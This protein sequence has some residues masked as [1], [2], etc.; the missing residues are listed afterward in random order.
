VP[1]GRALDVV[2][3]PKSFLSSLDVSA[4]GRQGLILTVTEPRIAASAMRQQF[5]SFVSAKAY[6][7]VEGWLATHIDSDLADASGLC[8][9]TLARRSG[10]LSG[11]EEA[12]MSR[13]A[14]ALPGIK[15]SERAYNAYLDVLRQ[16][17]F[18]K[19]A[20]ELRRA[21][22]TFETNPDEFKAMAR[23]VNA[24]TGRGEL[25]AALEKAAPVLNAFIFSPRNI[26]S[27]VSLLN[28]VTYINLPPAARKIALRKM[29]EFAGVAVSTL[30]AARFAGAAVELHPE[31]ADFLKIRVGKTHY[32]VLGGFQQPMR[33]LGQLSTGLW[34]LSQ[35]GQIK[36]GHDPLSVLARFGWT[37]ASPVA[38]YGISAA[39]GE[40]VD[41]SEFNAAT[42]GARQFAPLFLQD[43][44]EAWQEDGAAGAAKALPALVGVGVQTYGD[45]YPDPIAPALSEPVRQELARLGV[46]LE[47]LGKEGKKSASINPNYQTE[48]ITGDVA[49]F[50]DN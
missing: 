46:D 44:W 5:R 36:R 40:N 31:S 23:M 37:K 19:Y 15:H 2:G 9:A 6:R 27:R 10:R 7:E 28:P 30:T 33:L 14:G 34:K 50:I 41:G 11:R 8:R 13:I 26:A 47:H 43:M 24:M 12:F 42:D 29:V 20:D 39:M 18:S 38:G 35:G 32:D 22:L 17:S 1:P 45:M 25:P 16:K 4:P 49:Y 3:I 48:G 21:G